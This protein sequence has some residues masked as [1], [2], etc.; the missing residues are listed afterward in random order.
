M[1]AV[2][3]CVLDAGD[4]SIELTFTPDSD[5]RTRALAHGG[6]WAFSYRGQTL[7]DGVRLAVLTIADRLRASS[8][9]LTRAEL[10]ELVCG[11]S[12]GATLRTAHLKPAAPMPTWPQWVRIGRSD[13]LF[14]NDLELIALRAGLRRLVKREGHVHDELERD[15]AWLTSQA[16]FTGLAR[17]PTG[18]PV[19]FAAAERAIVDEAMEHERSITTSE[20][21]RWL[22]A[23]LGYPACCVDA[24][25][26]R[27][28]RDD[29]TLTRMGTPP[30]GARALPPE[31]LWVIGPLAL[32]SHAPCTHSCAAT[33]ALAK[34][35]LDELP[36]ERNALWRP[37]AARVHG[38]D[39]TGVPWSF[40]VA[41]PISSGT[42]K[43]AVRWL[44][45]QNEEPDL[46]GAAVEVSEDGLRVGDLRLHIAVDHRG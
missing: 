8:G 34:R 32:F 45:T 13:G 33:H 39:D 18:D 17:A 35:T 12:A 28:S 41:G 37:L 22:G 38:I 7:G 14:P 24:F 25:L 20:S 15:V 5:A 36:R 40:D 42:V 44:P 43:H 29:L 2:W 26:T 9:A 21:V 31:L 1:E 30:I 16:L 6:G 4:E 23:A 3:S 10:I 27:E 11:A 19:L 46:I